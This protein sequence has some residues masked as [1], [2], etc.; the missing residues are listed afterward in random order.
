MTILEH[1]KR[2]YI[3]ERGNH[4][5]WPSEQQNS[6]LLHSTVPFLWSQKSCLKSTMCMLML[7]SLKSL[8]ATTIHHLILSYSTQ[9]MDQV[10]LLRI[11]VLRQEVI[12]SV[13]IYMYM[14]VYL[15]IY[16][17]IYMYIYIYI[18]LHVYIYIYIYIYL[19]IYIYIY[20]YIICN[21]YA[22]SVVYIW[23]ILDMHRTGTKHIIRH[24]Q[25]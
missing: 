13:I 19:Y 15:S 25:K 10:T 4:M 20:I 8:K 6:E 14:C 16:L 24:M 17:S 3:R 7:W 2:C 21:L 5:S 11:T 18:Y 12:D 22:K 1:L 9:P 23:Q